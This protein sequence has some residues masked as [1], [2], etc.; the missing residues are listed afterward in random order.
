MLESKKILCFWKKAINE[1]I[2]ELLFI[3]C[4]LL[5]IKDPC[6][7][8]QKFGFDIELMKTTSVV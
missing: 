7:Q 8:A 6:N 5:S 2:L 4:L 1:I 3:N